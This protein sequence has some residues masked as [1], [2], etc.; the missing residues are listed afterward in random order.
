MSPEKTIANQQ[1][2]HFLTPNIR[3]IIEYN[4]FMQIHLIATAILPKKFKQSF[5]ILLRTLGVQLQRQIE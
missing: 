5:Y 2:T 4:V 1:E 3:A